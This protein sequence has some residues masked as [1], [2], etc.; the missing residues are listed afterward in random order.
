MMDFLNLISIGVAA[1]VATNIDDIF[2]LILF[3]SSSSLP[4]RQIVLGQYI[5]IGLLVS[6]STLGSF[7]PLVIPFIYYWVTGF[8]TRSDRCKEI[9]SA[10]KERR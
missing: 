7:L 2:L 9:S 5:G 3:L 1:F 10:H 6:I 8:G 4:V